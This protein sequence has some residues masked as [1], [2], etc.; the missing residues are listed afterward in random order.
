VLDASRNG[1]LDADVVA[2]VSN[3]AGA[4]GLERAKK[5]GVPAIV[6]PKSKE[7]TREVYDARLA[8]LVESYHPDLIVLAGWMRLL[9][10]AFIGRFPKKIINL[11]PALPGTFAGVNAIE[12]AYAAYENFE[13]CSTGVMVHYV[14]DESVDQGPVIDQQVVPIEPEYTLHDLE[15][16]IHACEHELLV[17]SIQ[18]L[19]TQMEDGHA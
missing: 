3:K 18:Q 13:I 2:V 6:F 7:E 9:T 1:T 5:A 16:K 15:A 19:V 11:H 8:D 10:M 14:L 4:V 17:K 12:R